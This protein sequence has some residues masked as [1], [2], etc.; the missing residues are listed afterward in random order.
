MRAPYGLAAVCFAAS[1]SASAKIGFPG[2]FFCSQCLEFSAANCRMLWIFRSV[3]CAFGAGAAVS[4]CENPPYCVIGDRFDFG[5]SVAGVFVEVMAVWCAP[6]TSRTV[7]CS[8]CAG[9]QF[10][11]VQSS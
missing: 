8:T 4:T 5:T 3:E 2:F 10:S 6:A 9:G 11:A 7:R 1:S